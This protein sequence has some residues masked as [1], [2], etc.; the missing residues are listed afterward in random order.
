MHGFNE[1][2]ENHTL[3]FLIRIKVSFFSF[4]LTGGP[5]IPKKLRT[6][7]TFYN[8]L[9]PCVDN[10]SHYVYFIKIILNLCTL[11]NYH[12]LFIYEHCNCIC[13]IQI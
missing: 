7:N 6:E 2:K 8:L 11:I 4:D 9:L 1:E 13:T 10:I 12:R 3:I 5:N